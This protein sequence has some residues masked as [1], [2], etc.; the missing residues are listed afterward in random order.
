MLGTHRPSPLAS[1]T[2]GASGCADASSHDAG[3]RRG[4]GAARARFTT[5]TIA[6]A[7][8]IPA[9]PAGPFIHTAEA[10]AGSV[11][12]GSA[13]SATVTMP[14]S[15]TDRRRDLAIE[16][17]RIGMP[18]PAVP[19]SPMPAPTGGFA[20]SPH[21]GRALATTEGGTVV[22][23]HPLLLAA[24]P[25]PAAAAA[26]ATEAGTVICLNPLLLV[27]A[28]RPEPA[29]VARPELVPEEPGVPRP[30]ADGAPEPTPVPAMMPGATAVFLGRAGA[31]RP[32]TR[33]PIFVPEGESLEVGSKRGSPFASDPYI[34]RYHAA[35]IPGQDGILVEDFGTANGVYVRVE[36]HAALRS[37][38]RLRLGQQLLRFHRFEAH[39]DDDG[40]QRIGSPDPAAW[41][42][43]AI[44]LD[45]HRE[46]AAY[47]LRA[48]VVELGQQ[49][50]HVQFPGD[51]AVGEP[52]CRLVLTD[53]GAH[54]EVDPDAPPT[55]VR[56]D[57]GDMVAYGSEILI[58]ETRV[59]FDRI[60]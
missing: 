7:A 2:A 46:A 36:G 3:S 31:T 53:D 16:H 9:A 27:P 6:V 24:A 26:L 45:P 18:L 23:L 60:P 17:T 43:L 41:G 12:R 22:A 35:L 38:D 49:T 51:A 39:S 44:M 14:I 28:A 48:P 37:D 5:T 58:G 33:T 11:A 56:L 52:H 59:R 32:E 1:P 8:P 54:V 13:P 29:P 50:G 20:A 10:R 40:V 47:P 55:Y 21:T 30:V 4:Q 15:V 57:R 42:R 19:P 34:A 25:S